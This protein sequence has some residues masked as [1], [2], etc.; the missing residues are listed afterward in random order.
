MPG[1]IFISPVYGIKVLG[2]NLSVFLHIAT[3]TA[4]HWG[5]RVIF[6]WFE[7]KHRGMRE[8][9]EPAARFFPLSWCLLKDFKQLKFNSILFIPA[10]R[11]TRYIN[12]VLM[13]ALCL[14][15]KMRSRS[16]KAKGI[17]F[18]VCE[19]IYVIHIHVNFFVL[20]FCPI[21]FIFVE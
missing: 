3:P 12:C 7:I 8:G 17:L 10:D 11:T 4:L 1:F 18:C 20:A 16:R 15:K 2:V 19:L 14:P 9:D 21:P 6:G 13:R 5:S